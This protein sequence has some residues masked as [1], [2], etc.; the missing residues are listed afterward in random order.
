MRV[1][2][3]LEKT[4]YIEHR[5]LDLDQSWS[6]NSAFFLL[7]HPRRSPLTTP[8][9]RASLAAAAQ[10]SK[11]R[12]AGAAGGAKK[13]GAPRITEVAALGGTYTDCSSWAVCYIINNLIE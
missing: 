13:T 10:D 7:P 3:F 11:C 1:H 6:Q 8:T 2:V 12:E 9:P 4:E 5:F